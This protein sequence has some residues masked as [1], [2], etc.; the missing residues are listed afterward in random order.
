MKTIE[1]YSSEKS[2]QTT[3]IVRQQTYLHKSYRKLQW[4][5]VHFIRQSKIIGELGKKNSQKHMSPFPFCYIKLLDP[6]FF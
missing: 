1:I 2:S 6:T 5:Y 4:N 3:N